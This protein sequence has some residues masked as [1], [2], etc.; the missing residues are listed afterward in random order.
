MNNLRDQYGIY[1]SPR[2]FMWGSIR[3]DLYN[4]SINH[5][6][7]EED[8][9]FYQSFMDLTRDYGEEDIYEVKLGESFHYIADYF[10]FAHNHKELKHN[11]Y[12][13][14]TYELK[15]HQKAKKVNYSFLKDLKPSLLMEKYNFRGFMEYKHQ[16][17]LK[18]WSGPES[19]IQ[20]SLQVGSYEIFQIMIG[21]QFDI[22]AS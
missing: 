4:D 14:M 17:Y 19:D 10:C 11:T 15:L 22:Y 2:L 21:K 8:N 20:Y 6:K 7:E 16:E 9:L 13:H 18:N 3:P 1:I 5:F 12:S